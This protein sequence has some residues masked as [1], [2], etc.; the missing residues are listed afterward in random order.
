MFNLTNRTNW[1]NPLVANSDERNAA[2]FLSLTNL[3]GGSGFPRSVQF[4]S[5]IA[6]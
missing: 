4:G 6:F 2:N 5:R 1:D 3:R